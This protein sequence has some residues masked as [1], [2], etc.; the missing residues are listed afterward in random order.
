MST[1]W[2]PRSFLLSCVL[3]PALGLCGLALADEHRVTFEVFGGGAVNAPSDL[4]VSQDG[5]PDIDET[6]TF[7]TKPFEQPLYWAVRLGLEDRAGAWELQLVHDKL[8]LDGPPAGIDRF[9]ITHGFN[10]V[11]LG[12]AFFLGRGLSVRASAGAAV[13]HSESTVRGESM[14]GGGSLSEYE[15]GGPAFLVSAGWRLPVGR[16]LFLT[17]E[18]ALS[19]A[20][21][22]VSV[23]HGH[24]TFWNAAAHGLVGLGIRFGGP[25]ERQISH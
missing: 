3:L 1:L 11:T 20:R 10:L 22:R 15:L 17:V 25:F 6:V 21:V 24:A 16:C 2:I 5:Q 7:R 18:G 13:T 23:A 14:G 19:V 8:Y 4:V 9:E 12:R